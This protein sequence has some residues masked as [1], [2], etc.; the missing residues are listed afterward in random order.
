[1]YL[2]AAADGCL[3]SDLATGDDDEIEEELRLT[4]V[5][6]TRARDFLYI[7][8]PLR[9]YTRNFGDSHVYAQ[10]CRFFTPDVLDT[11]DRTVCP[12]SEHQEDERVPD[13]TNHG[14]MDKIKDM[15]D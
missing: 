14:I 3:P 11:M 8:W 12:D 6:M 10:L 5:A 9:F 1:V 4:Y 2:I 13:M 15:W 7:L